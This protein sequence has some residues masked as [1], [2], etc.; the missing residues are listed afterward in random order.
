MK[1]IYINIISL[2]NYSRW[3]HG[4]TANIAVSLSN[5]INNDIVHMECPFNAN[6][7]RSTF[8]LDFNALKRME[9]PKIIV[10][11]QPVLNDGQQHKCYKRI[12]SVSDKYQWKI[13]IKKH[14]QQNI[15]KYESNVF[16]MH[17][18]KWYLLLKGNEL[19]VYCP[20]MKRNWVNIRAISCLYELNVKI[21]GQS[22]QYFDNLSYNDSDVAKINLE[23]INYSESKLLIIDLK[24]IL[25]DVFTSTS[26][27]AT[28]I[29]EKY[30]S[31]C[32][33][34][35]VASTSYKWNI[36]S[37]NTKIEDICIGFLKGL[38]N[39]YIE[40]KIISLCID[41]FNDKKN[42]MKILK[43]RKLN[44]KIFSPVFIVDSFQW[45]LVIEISKKDLTFKLQLLTPL[46]IKNK[47]EDI[48]V[49]WKVLIVETNQFFSSIYISSQSK[50]QIPN[51]KFNV[52][53][54]ENM[55]KMTVLANIVVLDVFKSD[56]QTISPSDYK[57][58]INPLTQTMCDQFQFTLKKHNEDDVQYFLFEMYCIKWY[59][60]V[61]KDS[62]YLTNYNNSNHL[63]ISYELSSTEINVS[64]FVSFLPL[65]KDSS[66][67]LHNLHLYQ[68]NNNV[69]L[70]ADKIMVN[71]V[72]NTY[73]KIICNLKIKLIDCYDEL[74]VQEL[75]C[76]VKSCEE[77]NCLESLNH[78]WK[79]ILINSNIA[80]L[81]CYG[82]ARE[83]TN[84]YI[85]NDI[86]N[87]LV[88]YFHESRLNDEFKKGR[89]NKKILKSDIFAVGPATVCITFTSN[90]RKCIAIPL[91]S[92]SPKIKNISLLCHVTMQTGKNC[93][94]FSR[95]QKFNLRSKQ[96]WYL[97][98]LRNI[99]AVFI[100]TIK[101]H[102]A[103]LEVLNSNDTYIKD[104]KK[105]QPAI[106]IGHLDDHYT[107]T[108]DF[109]WNVMLKVKWDVNK[110]QMFSMF[111]FEWYLSM[112]SRREY[113][114][115]RV[116]DIQLKLS[117]LPSHVCSIWIG[118]KIQCLQKN[119][120]SSGTVKF[121]HSHT[122]RKIS[123]RKFDQYLQVIE[124][125]KC[126]TFR[127]QLTLYD[128]YDANGYSICH[129]YINKK[130]VIQNS[131]VY[132]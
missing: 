25:I 5:N 81:I 68:T 63:S 18:L 47:I 51:W 112:R 4:F 43:D 82:F 128:V 104:Y 55:H 92:L 33:C 116:L 49:K 100:F 70:I 39:K 59:L 76:N 97:D 19:K 66:Y 29:T 96:E 52:N 126:I 119:I 48:K 1:T 42:D 60:F 106:A 6:K 10:K 22:F 23:T 20:S 9:V 89:K 36:L 45:V 35:E 8:S 87:L 24:L 83:S 102:L 72:F 69:H 120:S 86:N 114:V 98:N 30:F 131:I 2:S 67:A 108:N 75:T 113:W 132:G 44:S 41:Y 109:T 28:C 127:L 37:C 125:H 38:T 123:Q 62:L 7:T 12:L 129:K 15:I 77:I 101:I 53:N 11:I 111:D 99:D 32:N 71:D 118:Y 26:Y 90:W 54:L 107:N 84:K 3:L 91:L 122:E 65:N 103:I 16:E 56:T 121:D 17:S 31:S 93:E 74:G 58:I 85:P 13:S 117:T 79:V 57:M 88:L 40:Y 110:S 94:V 124:Q 27:S 50:H 78:K 64:G 95:I 80:K 105:Y 115:G 14:H 61:K 130:N 46:P 21:D 73:D 34:K